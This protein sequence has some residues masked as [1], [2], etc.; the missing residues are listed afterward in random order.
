MVRQWYQPHLERIYDDTRARGA[1]LDQLEQ[2]AGGYG[3]RQ[4]FLAE[5][6][7]DPPDATGTD[8]EPPRLDEDFL[9]LSTIHS[10][11]GQEW[12]AVFVINA[13]D[14]GIPSDMAVGSP[15][16]LEEER[17]LLY[18]AMTRARDHLHIVHPLRFFRRQQARQGDGHVY[19][20]LSRFIPDDIL[21]NFERR[22]HG[23]ARPELDCAMPARSRIDVAAR[24][25][26][27]WG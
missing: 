12:N 11:K 7:L 6:T 21:D 15:E 3:T 24:A 10:A 22:A 17:R 1:D 18:V 5:L 4:R 27:M 2:I 26:A 19:A 23:R 25:R 14:G 9:T 20:Q 8:A 16:Q 13:A